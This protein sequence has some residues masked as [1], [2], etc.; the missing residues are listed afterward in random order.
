MPTYPHNWILDRP[1]QLWVSDMTYIKNPKSMGVFK[2][3]YRCLVAQDH[4]LL[5]AQC[6]M[7]AEG[8]IAALQMALANRSYQEQCLI[9]HSD[10]G[11]QYCCKQYVDVLTSA[12]IAISDDR[13]RRP[14]MKMP[15]Q[16]E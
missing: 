16:S 11:A 6:D 3:D 5:S 13:K 15:W 4:G 14:R 9:H 10:R 7:L 1:E 2:L 12:G 8:C